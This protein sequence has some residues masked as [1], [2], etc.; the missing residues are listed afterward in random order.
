M[1][2]KPLLFVICLSI[3]FSLS[4][5]TDIAYASEDTTLEDLSVTIDLEDFKTGESVILYEDPNT[6][7]KLIVDFIEAKNTRYITGTDDWSQGYIPSQ[8]VTMYVHYET[9]VSPSI[10][11]RYTDLG[12][13]VTYD[14]RN[15]TILETYSPTIGISGGV[16]SNVTTRIITSSPTPSV[17]AKSE[18]TWTAR[19]L[20]GNYISSYL[21]QEINQN[22]QMRI[23]WRF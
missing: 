3:F 18:M 11:Y 9:P 23:S 13:Y 22:N 5:C 16:V 15:S 10:I 7:G 17:Y 20:F 12:Y 6:G 4:F 1:K 19:D 2:F 8:V 21:R 14:G